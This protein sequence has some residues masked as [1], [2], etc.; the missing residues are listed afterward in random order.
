MINFRCVSL[1]SHKNCSYFEGGQQELNNRAGAI[2]A[3]GGCYV[4]KD[5]TSKKR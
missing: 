5:K 2:C 4:L 3:E 1:D